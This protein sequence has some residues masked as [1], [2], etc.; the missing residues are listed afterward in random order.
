VYEAAPGFKYAHYWVLYTYPIVCVVCFVMGMAY[1]IGTLDIDY[2]GIRQVQQW[3]CPSY[4]VMI[5]VFPAFMYILG[6]LALSQYKQRRITTCP[7]VTM[8]AMFVVI[9]LFCL[10]LSFASFL[11]TVHEGDQQLRVVQDDV[12]VGNMT[13][14][15]YMWKHH[16]IT[17]LSIWL[18]NVPLLAPIITA[19][20]WLCDRYNP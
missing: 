15:E 10:L 12:T 7:L 19:L 4:M 14:H 17:I 6:V 13:C 16:L 20:G 18:L 2:G 9:Q 11:Q 3:N 8:G 5:Y 1:P